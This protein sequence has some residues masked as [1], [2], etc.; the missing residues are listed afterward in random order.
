MRRHPPAGSPGRTSFRT[1]DLEAARDWMRT[2]YGTSLRMKSPVP[3][4][5]FSYSRTLA[6]PVTLSTLALDA[7]Y[8]YASDPLDAVAIT[9]VVSGRMHRECAGDAL[10]AGPGDVLAISQPDQPYTG[11]VDGAELH[12]VS[13][14]RR[15]VEDAAGRQPGRPAPP[16][17]FT[18]FTPV[19]PALAQQWKEAVAYLES[20]VMAGPAAGEP[21]VLDA[22]ARM[23]AAH[24]LTT[25][26]NTAHPVPVPA[27][28]R[29]ATS[30]TVRRAVAFI[31]SAPD[32]GIGLT[33][34]AAAAG[35]TPRALQYAFRR[36]A[37]TTPTAYLRRVRLDLAHADLLAG[38]PA[39]GVGV[40]AIAHRWGFHH[41]GRF[42]AAYRA[43]Y[44]HAPSRTLGE[45]GPVT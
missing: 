33:E 41:L 20:G 14:S 13:L 12:A 44:G 6:G 2:S 24:V 22:A 39:D 27:D 38:D 1:T 7:E 10:A 37:G 19:S 40:A 34:M 15:L 36:H 45:S 32:A 42:A 16:L 8:V 11:R 18:R 28:T 29:D 9:H 26:P 30:E 43:A 21:L 17:R 5:T 4:G 35:V 31:E 3:N 23:I 25:F